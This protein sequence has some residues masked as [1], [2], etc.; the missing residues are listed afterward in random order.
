MKKFWQ[1]GILILTILSII[2]GQKLVFSSKYLTGICWTAAGLLLL[3]FLF[4]RQYIINI[5]HLIKT[6]FYYIPA[7]ISILLGL[8][9]LLI[10]KQMSL[11]SLILFILS[12][13]F[14]LISKPEEQKL[15]DFSEIPD[16]NQPVQLWEI[17][18]VGILI[19]FVFVSR[20]WNFDS[21]P[22]GAQGH[23]GTV[24]NSY[25]LLKS[26]YIAF[27]GDGLDWPTLIYYQGMFFADI[28]GKYFTSFRIPCV[29]WGGLAV[30]AFYFVARRLTSPFTALIF[31]FVF[32]VQEIFLIFSRMAG[33]HIA[34]FIPHILAFG[35]LILAMKKDKWWLFLAAGIAAG[36]G[37]HAYW[38]GRVVPFIF[39]FWFIWL[40]LFN[41][42]AMPSIKNQLIFWIGFLV[43][44]GPVL[45]V[46]ITNPGLYW[47]YINGINP[48]SGKGIIGYLTTIK[49]RLPV[50]MGMFHVK[51]DMYW[52]FKTS[53]TP[54]FDY[55]LQYFFPIGLFLCV[56]SFWKPV[57]SF[58]IAAF[59]AGMLVG[60]LGGD[61]LQHPTTN[62]IIM[63]YPVA[64]LFAALAF[65]R[66][67]LVLNRKSNKI[68]S[69]VIILIGISLTLWSV[70][71]G[72]N[73]YFNVYMKHPAVITSN[74]YINYLASR[75]ADNNKDKQ[76]VLTH[77]MVDENSRT[78]IF[79]SKY[80]PKIPYD[81]NGIF[82]LNDKKDYL[83]TFP[84]HFEVMADYMHTLF[85]NSSV[86]K[87][88]NDTINH[89]YFKKGQL[90][91]QPF[92]DWSD[93]FNKD[94]Y[95][96]SI[97]VPKEDI[98]RF[99]DV[100]DND[101]NDVAGA[102]KN[103]FGKR[104]SGKTTSFSG[105]IILDTNYVRFDDEYRANTFNVQF[106]LPWKNWTLKVNENKQE[107]NKQFVLNRG[108]HFFTIKGQIPSNYD[109]ILPLNIISEGENLTENGTIIFSEELIKSDKVVAIQK[110]VG[111]RVYFY[112]QNNNWDGKPLFMKQEISYILYFIYLK[113]NC[114]Y[115]VKTD[116]MLQVPDN[117]K[118]VF[119]TGPY[120]QGRIFIN[121]KPIFKNFSDLKKP[122]INE[123]VYLEA[124][125]KYKIRVDYIFYCAD[126][127]MKACCIYFKKSED[128]KEKIV[129]L[130]WISP[131]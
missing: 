105:A 99:H 106:I 112:E 35:L 122:E 18:C 14:L 86:K 74:D 31:S 88:V 63:V 76:L 109:G 82:I 90:Q 96:V 91:Y 75:E 118:Y 48:N 85:P 10:V 1:Y 65:E 36:Y 50:Y 80:N 120:T 127:K 60:I 54:I 72:L 130:D 16:K 20:F 59:S 40:F 43:I 61:N 73:N 100:I 47:G 129:P 110:P 107:F 115:S 55:V 30:I 24:A 66:M 6:N 44:S 102:F 87:Y 21:V 4:F 25:D 51:S 46:A 22:P 119:T 108:I 32:S 71:N 23:E 19:I 111:V 15:L 89:D 62:R 68:V 123:S 126:S 81:Y 39:L 3:L 9:A 84:G 7:F 64:S 13:F 128:E 117:G 121:D 94:L 41:R 116:G 52:G 79:Y 11:L 29:I 53:Y 57:S 37:L 34:C 26:K 78:N 124:G 104:Y 67:R 12:G 70:I 93:P 33:T 28:F 42:K 5:N 97:V 2:Y 95:M 45:Y 103:D 114:P 58:L 49:T 125:K 98:N 101:T 56:F 17:I 69:F 83:F 8:I 131:Y 77:Y 27:I 113:M 92:L 38:P